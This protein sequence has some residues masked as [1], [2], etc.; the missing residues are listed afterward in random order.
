M[1]NL[2]GSRFTDIMP[3]NL[4]S[5]LETQAFAYALGRQIEKLCTYADGVHIYAAVASMPEK[6][7]DVLAIE[8]QTPAYNQ[9]LSVEVK[10][11]LIKGT[12]YFYS[13]LGT[14]AA[15]NWVIRSVFGNGSMEDWYSYG[16]EPHHFRVYVG[17]GGNM[18]TLE[19]LS[20]FYRLVARIKRLSSWLDEIQLISTPMTATLRYAG[21]FASYSRTVLPEWRMEQSFNK[22]INIAGAFAV[23]SRTGLPPVE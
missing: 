7:L 18:A 15:V 5:Q 11:E 22:T 21:A 16:G 13:R 8:L 3:E 4:A 10:R 12:L 23:R 2:Q 14:P 9:Q 17:N 19:N 1:I 6:I 20:E